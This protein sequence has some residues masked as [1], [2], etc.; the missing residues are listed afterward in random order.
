MNE[1]ERFVLIRKR[2]K[3]KLVER[4]LTKLI[5]IQGAD[6]PYSVLIGNNVRFCHNALGTVI[7][8]NTEIEDKDLIYQNV[9]VGR[10]LPKGKDKY[11]YQKKCYYLCRCQGI[12]KKVFNS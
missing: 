11:C 10:A 4:I 12:I 8:P 1:V 9:I 6:I 3:S 5:F 7:S 2:A